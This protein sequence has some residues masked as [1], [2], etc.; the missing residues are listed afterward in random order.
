MKKGWLRGYKGFK[1]K[2]CKEDVENFKRPRKY[3]KGTDKNQRALAIERDG[4]KCRLCGSSERLEVHHIKHKAEGG[5]DDLDNLI[6][7]CA[8]CHAKQH[9]GEPIH[10]LM[11]SRLE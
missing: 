5:T 7:L 6:T 8:V 3:R 9:E 10:N 2:V 1:W 4:G 11:V